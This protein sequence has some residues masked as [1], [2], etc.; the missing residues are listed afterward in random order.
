MMYPLVMLVENN[1]SL[2]LA[3]VTNVSSFVMQ[4]KIRFMLES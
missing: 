1:A 2:I 3:I 4:G